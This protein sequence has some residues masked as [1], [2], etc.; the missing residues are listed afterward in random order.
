MCV[1][2]E[3]NEDYGFDVLRSVGTS[4]QC[5]R[6]RPDEDRRKKPETNII[7]KV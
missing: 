3:V 2:L 1:C 6:R 4:R 7:E 5:R